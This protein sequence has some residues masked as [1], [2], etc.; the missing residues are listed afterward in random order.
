M[1]SENRKTSIDILIDIY[2]HHKSRTAIRFSDKKKS[3]RRDRKIK[4]ELYRFSNSL[5]HVRYFADR[6]RH[7]DINNNCINNINVTVVRAN[8]EALRCLKKF[9]K[10]CFQHRDSSDSS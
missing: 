2:F 6:R 10:Y 7:F 4:K 1:V 9:S 5:R 3:A 8:N